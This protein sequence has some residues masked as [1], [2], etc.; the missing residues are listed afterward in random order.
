M[1]SIRF[2]SRLS[3]PYL[4]YLKRLK[5]DDF[6]YRTK[7]LREP[8]EKFWRYFIHRFTTNVIVTCHMY[9][10]NSSRNIEDFVVSDL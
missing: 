9:P 10:G 2:V 4:N 8:G 7:M 6:V 3:T 1:N 5:L